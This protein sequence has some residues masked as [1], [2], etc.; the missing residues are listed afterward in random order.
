M[1]HALETGTENPY[2]KTCT[3]FLQVCHANRYR[4]FSSTEIWYWVEQCSTRCRKP[5]P[6]W[7]ILI[8]QTIASSSCVICLYKLCCLLFYCYRKINPE[9]LLPVSSG[10]TNPYQKTGTSFLVRVF[11][12]GFWCV[13]HWHKSGGTNSGGENMASLATRRDV[14]SLAGSGPSPGRHPGAGPSPGWKR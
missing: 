7:R 11:G 14:N 2:Q 3:F 5:W 12:A 1:T 13:C 4:F 9:I 10:T 8:G 6:K